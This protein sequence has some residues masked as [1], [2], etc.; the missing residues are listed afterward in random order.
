[1]D[2]F[3]ALADPNRRR[4]I[5]IIASRGAISASDISSQFSISAPA[6]SQHLKVLREAELV[7]M[8]KRAQQ[9]IYSINP[10]GMDET[11]QWLNQMRQFWSERLD[12]LEELLQKENGESHA[13]K[14][15]RRK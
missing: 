6:I 4:I 14:R 3:A 12:A 13:N 1:M 8:E 9:R 7:R 11:W 2:R 15:N 10:Q 5:E